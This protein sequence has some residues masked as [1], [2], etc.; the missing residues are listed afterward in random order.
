MT[1]KIDH[2][3]IIILDDNIDTLYVMSEMIKQKFPNYVCHIFTDANQKFFDFVKSTDVDLFVIDIVLNHENGIEISEQLCKI[4]PYATFLFMSGYDYSYE[5]VSI[6]DCTNVFDFIKKPVP[7]DIFIN[8]IQVLLQASKN[9]RN[10]TKKL[11]CTQT[12][13]SQSLWDIFNYSHFFV[14]ALNKKMDVM[15]ANYFLATT[16]GFE[17]EKELIG[18]NWLKFVSEK[19]KHVIEYLYGEMTNKKITKEFINDIITKENKIIPVRWFNTNLDQ[20]ENGTFSIGVPI[21]GK[22]SKQDTEETIRSYWRDVIQENKTTV[23]ALREMFQK[24]SQSTKIEK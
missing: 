1:A 24:I 12:R 3:T 7:T 9:Y 4:N 2:A 18:K 19:D 15:L 11:K 17:T 20:G 10:I 21:A 23:N 8:R 16:L 6:N 14:M 13:L 22:V 5:Y